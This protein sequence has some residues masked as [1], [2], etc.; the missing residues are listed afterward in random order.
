MKQV[1][2]ILVCDD[3]PTTQTVV[4]TFLER[5]GFRVLSARNALE[6]IGL[7]RREKPDLILMDILMPDLDGTTASDLLR[8]VPDF[9]SIPVVLFSALPREE[10]A[11]RMSQTG[12]VAFLE[13][14]FRCR[15]LL[16]IV[17]RWA[18]RPMSA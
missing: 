6:G 8:E 18:G 7:V 2:L 11:E 16:E 10:I 14:P 15:Q 12:A 3:D 9:A 17:S 13:K 1:P 4:R 5:A